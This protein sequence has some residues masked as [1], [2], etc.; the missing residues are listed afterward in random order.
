MKRFTLLFAATVMSALTMSVCAQ[1]TPT[2]QMEKLD[3][4][5]VVVPGSGGKG[6]F[7]SWRFLGT[8]DENTTFQILRNGTPL[9]STDLADKTNYKDTYGS[10]SHQ[11]QIVTKH[12]GVA[13]DTTETI[14]RW[15]NI[16][17][18]I[19]LDRPA[20][21]THGGTYSPNDCSAGDVDG[22]G[23]YEII[24]KWDPNNSKDNSQSGKTDKVY[25]DC[26]KLD[27]TKLWRIDLG[28]NI[29]AGAHY[30][31]FMV[32]D[33]DGNGKAELIC[34]TAQG[35]KDGKGNYVNQ[36]ADDET[37]KAVVNTKD[38]RN[39]DGKVTG[40]QEWL[41]VFN[42]ETGAAIHT[43]FYN[44]NRATTYGG[45]PTWTFNWDDRSGKT[46]KE[47][48]NRGE[49]YLA[50]V[51]YLDGPDKNASAV[52]CR[53]YYTY[54][55]LWAVDFDGN[56]L[57]HRWLHSSKWN[58]GRYSV[59]D[60]DMKVTSYEAGT[61]TR[62]SGSKTAYGNGNHN[63][64]CADVDGDGSDEIIW[65][66]S[67]IDHDGKLLYATGYGHGDAMHV[68]DLDPTNPGLEVFTVHEAS[69]YGSD[70]HDAATGKILYS[71]TADGDTGRGIAAD[72]DGQSEG[73][74]YWDAKN[75]NPRSAVTGKT[76]NSTTP[77][78]NFR[79][80]WDGDLQD[81]LLDGNSLKKYK[82]GGLS[83]K[84]IDGKEFWDYGN[85][86][87]CNSTKKTPCLVADLL[88]DWREEVIFW[89]GDTSDALY[90][91][92]TNTPS[93]FRIPTLM[94]D[95]TYRLAVAWQNVAYNQPPHLGYNLPEKFK[96]RF[97]K[98]EAGE[99]EQWVNVGDSIVPFGVKTPYAG[100]PTLSAIINPNGEK[101]VITET[102]FTYTRNTTEKAITISGT[103][104]EIGTYQFV[105]SSGVSTVDGTKVKD[106]LVVHSMDPTAIEDVF[107]TSDDN[108]VSLADN[109]VDDQFS[110]NFNLPTAQSVSISIYTAGGA[111]VYA[112]T[113]HVNKQGETTIDGL[114]HLP[115]SI[116]MVRAK[117]ADNEWTAKIIKK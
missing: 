75:R 98:T 33:F 21:G 38:W 7:I 99:W 49:R 14:T 72:I 111:Q 11:Y 12:N 76:V 114:G 44:P 71:A 47:Y 27:G 80:Y 88:G 68:S 29:R 102:G 73:F 92:T 70:V 79:M 36:V 77:S 53:G 4:G 60:A 100:I 112:T 82:S 31:Q 57:K 51:A 42:G 26:Y 5:A 115:C 45:A 61:A 97:V 103:P 6:N 58:Y 87:T 40:G 105:I 15:S 93:D 56:K 2:S 104:S 52:M 28:V 69:P 55:F 117:A 89:D 108:W 10:V 101:V 16:Y 19:P 106:T 41:T 54:A 110:L 91:F 94:H 18:R 65:G 116:Y 84:L 32:W 50:T 113:L 22:D 67:A 78:M 37:I 107:A 3:R 66:A 83:G 9:L 43:I 13:V 64:S 17:N 74:E 20:T 23:Q 63:L 95:H 25:L 62:G 30:T 59:T 46:D 34:K 81:E 8:D 90:L 1:N 86:A 39:S 35:T 96:P 24:V 109:I 85:M 48:G